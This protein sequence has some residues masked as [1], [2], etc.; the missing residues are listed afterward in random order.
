M[1]GRTLLPA[2]TAAMLAAGSAHGASHREAPLIAIDAAADNTDVYFFISYD[3][4]NLARAPEDRRVTL[5]ANFIPGQEPGD[6]QNY[7]AF[8]DDVVYRLLI[9]HNADGVAEDIV[10]EF[11]FTTEERPIA[12]L[13][14]TPLPFLGG[15]IT[16]GITALDGAGSEG[17]TR[18]QTYTVTEI[19]DGFATELFQGEPLVAVPSNIGPATTPDYEDL[20]SQGIYYDGDLRV[21][22]GQRTETFAIDLGA[23]FD[24]AN[25]RA[26]P[27]VLKRQQDA[28]DARDPFGINRFSG[29]NISTI[30]I[31]LP[32]AD[33]TVD[34]FPAQSSDGP[35]TAQP[36]IG[37]YASASR[38]KI[39]T[40]EGDGTTTNA[41]PLV[42]VS[43]MANPLVNELIIGT[44]AKDF[45]N[46]SE[47]EDEAQFQAFFQNPTLAVALEAVF[48][49]PV[50]PA[51]RTDLMAALLKYPGQP[52]DGINCGNPCSD[53]LRLDL[54]V[55]PTPGEE[56]SRLGAA[57]GGDPAGFPNGRRPNDDVTDI[58]LRLV[59]GPNYAAARVGDGVNF[60]ADAP[61]AGT[62][63]GPGYG[64]IVGNLLDVTDNGIAIEFPFLPTPHDGVNRQ[65]IDCDE[66]AANNCI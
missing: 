3:E 23:V 39:R 6:G 42:Q 40:L 16:G 30:A 2:V 9:D 47:P 4:E 11:R 25:L 13:E 14:G 41:G 61:G 19:R 58:A 17:L 7:F 24:T 45:W 44:P 50:P 29:F 63:D 12:G 18:R 43:R 10:Y 27:P 46:A 59:G 60:L 64:A 57:F 55:A 26:S 5:I 8:D 65:H 48:G 52:L 20:A 22:V 51:P 15:V 54:T 34:G 38:S 56:Q 33:I 62:S 37:V 49:L 1:N 21:F 53:L 36:V 31:E 28:N 32:I 35:V 66:P